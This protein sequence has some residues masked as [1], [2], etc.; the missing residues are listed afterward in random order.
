MFNR[1][2]NLPG[3]AK[4]R[5][6][7]FSSA[8]CTS[9]FT[10]AVLPLGSTSYAATETPVATAVYVQALETLS[11]QGN[12]LVT[13][14][15][16]LKQWS[17]MKK[18]P[19]LYQKISTESGIITLRDDGKGGDAKAYDGIYSAITK[20]DFD[21]LAKQYERLSSFQSKF[22]KSALPLRFAPNRQ[23]LGSEK[24]LASTS[25]LDAISKG[26][27]VPL[28]PIGIPVA[29]NKE[30]SLLIRDSNVVQDPSRTFDICTGSGDPNGVWT[31]KHL[32]TEM[33]N[34]AVTGVTPEEFVRMWLSHWESDQVINGHLVSDREAGI[35]SLIIDPWEAASGGPGSQL[36]LDLA[37]FQLLAIVNRVDL[38]DNVTY[39][40]GSAGE[41]RFVFQVMENNCSPTQFTVIFE[42]GI[43]KNSCSAV[44]SW[45]QQWTDLG[46]MVLGS[47]AYNA[48][49]E[50]ITE[51]FVQAN[52]APSKP[53]GSALNQLRTNEIQ[54]GFF[55][56]QPWQLREFVIS[57]SGWNQHFLTQN[58]V[59]Q[60][61]ANS[62]DGTLELRNFVNSGLTEV[63][64]RWPTI[65]DPFKGGASEAPSSLFAWD[66]VG[67]SP[68]QA[69]HEFSLNT[70][71][72]CH[73]GET[74]TGFT[75]VKPGSIPASLSGFM[76]GINVAD[77]AD[78]A[79]T[80][81]FNDLARR[82]NDLDALVNS[83]CLTQLTV[84]ELMFPH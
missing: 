68:R 22:G 8:I 57:N 56:G 77:P 60:T 44:K 20:F 79:P 58:T 18:K 82:A 50:N 31:F 53:N 39:G 3:L 73:A 46:S 70:C 25:I 84:P 66:E 52:A 27:A 13:A 63:P 41:G 62:L 80:R 45:G 36:N 12:A 48:A 7:L 28:L 16:D 21:A 32:M 74:A 30:K 67:I 29:I 69:R 49:L 47:P 83:S 78:G 81:H 19:P 61:P 15:Y 43:E 65:A 11:K 23:L 64:L 10:A 1:L 35:K 42:Y 17:L 14:K 9:F 51:S 40:G 76:T 71:N 33:A 54:L 72:G 55:S 26:V 37:P 75:H 38:R 59:N 4:N 2:R 34:T 6:T 5:N 24:I